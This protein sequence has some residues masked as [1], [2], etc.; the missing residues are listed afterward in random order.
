MN[1]IKEMPVERDEYGCW[2]H[3]EY[4][5]F[6][7]GREYIS[8][9]EFDAW[10]K[11]NNLQWTIRS[12]DEDHFNL[13]ADGPDI[14]AWEPERPEGEGWF[15]GSIHDTEDGPVCIWLREKVAA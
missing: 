13:D 5:K 9:E 10:M 15:V 4:E 3:P 2:T 8:T 7:A 11:E 6:C 12:M 1:T 14:A